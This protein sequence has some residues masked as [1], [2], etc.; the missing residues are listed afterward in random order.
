MRRSHPGRSL[1]AEILPHL[2]GPGRWTVLLLAGRLP[3]VL[4]GHEHLERAEAV[5]C[6]RELPRRWRRAMR[7]RAKEIEDAG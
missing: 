5:A 7:E 4:C 2:G 3:V 1:H 6:A